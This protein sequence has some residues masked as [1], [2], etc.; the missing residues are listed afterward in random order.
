MRIDFFKQVGTISKNVF[1]SLASSVKK[2]P[3]SK[4]Q[5]NE[6]SG[7]LVR[8]V[9]IRYRLI[10]SFILVSL[11]PLLL[12]GLVSYNL[13]SSAIEGKV[14]KYSGEMMHQIAKNLNIEIKK[15]ITL[16]NTI[17]YD[18]TIQE[19]AS[20]YDE[21]SDID[22]LDVSR[23]LNTM[24]S[25]MF[26]D[27]KG[28]VSVVLHF[29]KSSSDIAFG[30]SVDPA[31]IKKAVSSAPESI[32]SVIWTEMKDSSGK[33]T[34]TLVRNLVSLNTGTE[35]CTL[36]MAI[37]SSSLAEVFKEVNL[38]DGSAIYIAD[39]KSRIV[40][41]PD[42]KIN[43]YTS[44]KDKTLMPEVIKKSEKQ[45][46]VFEM[47][48]NSDPSLISFSPLE[49]EGWFIVG[50][51]PFSYL[52]REA[53]D[54]LRN[55]LVIIFICFIFAVLLSY[56]ISSSISNPSMK[57]RAAMTQAKQGN[58]TVKL[59][60]KNKDEI[61]EIAQYFDEM[62]ENI[63]NL[64]TKVNSSST[65]VLSNSDKLAESSEQS[66]TTSEQVAESV[67]HIATGASNQAEEISNA[68]EYINS[69]SSGIGKVGVEMSSVVNVVNST[70]S[71]SDEAKEIINV[72]NEKAS[73]TSKSSEKIV[74]DIN[75][76]NLDMREIKKIVKVIVGIA[77]QT[78]LLSLN[79]AIEAARAGEA[80]RGF[81]VVA[82]EVKK[83]A[84]QS[85]EASITINNIITSI[86]KKTEN[87]AEAANNS[88]TIIREQMDTV[89]K[90]D[91]SFK[92]IFNALEN[93]ISS[94][95]SM[96]N[97][98]NDT[99]NLREKVVGTIESIAAVSEETAATSEEVSA[100]TQEQIASAEE[101]AS[102]AKDLSN[103]AT[104]LNNEVNKF[105]I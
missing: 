31:E 30:S 24:L 45:Q 81:A 52:N 12:T 37:D 25:T 68:V 76:L 35:I 82:D 60:D 1:G 74:T 44:L 23:E 3:F 105:K 86:Q 22:K 69:L 20:G 19:Q 62:L 79:A 53:L 32:G 80:G 85:K 54:L 41:T 61:G 72:L 67:Q 65:A 102:L 8:I 43:P 46:N 88:S 87:T 48:V 63:R 18:K 13:A 14:N 84:D 4:S 94:L 73:Q 78:N 96:E 66:Y 59:N 71:R 21:K 29:R 56:I 83:L 70:I 50:T 64:L 55:T 98:V 40:A 26:N 90:T 92:S 93:V 100:S 38:G 49:K 103:M 42:A 28:I 11:I 36:V 51:V 17:L 27:Q 6:K 99:L 33:I 101:L 34:P 91:D 9:K 47:A 15:Y 89:K 95:T 2:I 10:L 7:S 104:E 58:L 5:K 57:L 39:D 77:E 16:S 97:S 75:S